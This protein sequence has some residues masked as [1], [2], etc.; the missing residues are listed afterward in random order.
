MLRVC[1]SVCFV[2]HVVIAHVWPFISRSACLF[3]CLYFFPSVSVFVCRS[4]CLN[5]CLSLI[6][7]YCFFVFLCVL[8][9]CSPVP[10]CVYLSACLPMIDVFISGCLSLCVFPCLCAGR[11]VCDIAR[12]FVCFLF[13]FVQ[14][15]VSWCSPLSPI[16]MCACSICLSTCHFV[17]LLVYP[18]FFCVCFSTRALSVCSHRCSLLIFF[19][20][21]VLF[22][23]CLSIQP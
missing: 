14:V 8:A 23:I 15:L 13:F 17:R 10:P 1:F 4:A 11:S 19:W 12:L 7:F 20:L 16:C 2:D 5:V 6:F 3:V 22:R 18:C 21:P 9:F